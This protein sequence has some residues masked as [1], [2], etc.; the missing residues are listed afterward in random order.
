LRFALQERD[1]EA[2]TNSRHAQDFELHVRLAMPFDA[3]GAARSA[4]TPTV[5]HLI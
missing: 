2:L 3:L 1:P 4:L 5:V